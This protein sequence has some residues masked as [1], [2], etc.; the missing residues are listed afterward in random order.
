MNLS[1]NSWYCT[2]SVET[3]ANSAGGLQEAVDYEKLETWTRVSPGDYEKNIAAVIDLA[4]DHQAGAILLYNELSGGAGEGPVTGQLGMTSPY[5]M[6]LEKVSM[7]EGVPVVDSSAII[8]EARRKVEEDLERKLDLRP[9]P[10]GQPTVTDKVEV[11]FRVYLGNRPVPEAVYIVGA[12]PELGGGVPNKIAMY[13]DGT[14]GDQK[15]GD[16][17]WSYSAALSPGERIFLRLYE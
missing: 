16:S 4:R 11:I 7:G 1:D 14:H 5:R 17:V 2:F 3:R 10:A 9:H 12:H 6:A 8:A 15:A 13:D